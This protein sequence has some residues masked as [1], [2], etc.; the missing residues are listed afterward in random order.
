[1]QKDSL[2]TVGRPECKQTSH[3]TYSQPVHS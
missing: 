3:I 2:E 1:L